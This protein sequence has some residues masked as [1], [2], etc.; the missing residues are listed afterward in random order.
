MAKLKCLLVAGNFCCFVNTFVFWVLMVTNCFFK[1]FQ[2]C[3]EHHHDIERTSKPLYSPWLLQLAWLGL[4]VNKAW[5]KKQ[6]GSNGDGGNL[7]KQIRMNRNGFAQTT[8]YAGGGGSDQGYYGLAYR[9][10]STFDLLFGTDCRK[11]SSFF[12]K[13]WYLELGKWYL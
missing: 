12:F 5:L 9:Q 2:E 10:V 7:L 3:S 11:N 1:Y 4:T 6:Q 13:K 8:F